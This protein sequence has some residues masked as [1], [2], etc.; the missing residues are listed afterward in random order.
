MVLPLSGL[1]SSKR[2]G[3]WIL[4]VPRTIPSRCTMRGGGGS[5]TAAAGVDV[6]SVGA[7]VGGGTARAGVVAGVSVGAATTGGASATV[8]VLGAGSVGV[9]AGAAGASCFRYCAATK[10][11]AS[12]GG[13]ISNHSPLA[14]ISLTAS[15]CFRVPSTLKFSPGPPRMLSFFGRTV[16]FVASRNEELI[17]TWVVLGKTIFAQAE[18]SS[19]PEFLSV[20]S[21]S[22]VTGSPFVK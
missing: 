4:K 5:S 12:A 17:H 2:V 1:T 14:P 13:S 19:G 10:A 8:A 15:P 16:L 22:T 18:G 6:I 9:V 11:N 7:L 3:A 20:T 21:S